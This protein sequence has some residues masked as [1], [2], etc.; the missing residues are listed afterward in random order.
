MSAQQQESKKNY[1][2]VVSDKT[3]EQ[4]ALDLLPKP[5]RPAREYLLG[6]MAAVLHRAIDAREPSS[7]RPTTTA[8]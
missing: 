7:R 3:D 1:I 4:R 6:L 5:D 2:G 8:R